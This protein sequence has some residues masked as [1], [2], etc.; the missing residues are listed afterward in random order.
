MSESAPDI[1]V[2]KVKY[3]GTKVRVEYQRKRPDDRYDEAAIASFDQ[4]SPVFRAALWNLS[5]DVCAIAEFHESYGDKLTVRGASFT[6]S[7]GGVMGACI[8]ALAGVK[9][10]KAPLVLNTPFLTAGPINDGDGGPF[11]DE[12]TVARLEALQAAAIAYINGD[13]EQP[14]LELGSPDAPKPKDGEG[15]I[16]Y[17]KRTGMDIGAAFADAF[18]NPENPLLKKFAKKFKNCSFEA[19]GRRVE[20]DGHGNITQTS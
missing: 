12:M 15:V 1:I 14:K 7:D 5:Q 3:D 18:T 19:G 20:I 6:Y 8:T 17:A 11:L 10:A 4:P 2:D 13:R 16:E 9:T